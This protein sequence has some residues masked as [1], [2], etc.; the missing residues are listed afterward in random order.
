MKELITG[1]IQGNDPYTGAERS[2]KVSFVVDAST[3]WIEIV[4][5]AFEIVSRGNKIEW[6][7][8]SLRSEEVIG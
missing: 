6:N 4:D 1:R 8:E 5:R 2:R 3:P 7:D